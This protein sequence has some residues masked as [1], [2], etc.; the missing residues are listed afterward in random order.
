MEPMAKGR[1]ANT[2]WFISGACARPAAIATPS[3]RWRNTNHTISPAAPASRAVVCQVRPACNCTNPLS[4]ASVPPQ[5]SIRLSQ[6]SGDLSS[7]AAP[8]PGALPGTKR[9]D[10]HNEARQNGTTMEKIERHPNR[11][12][13]TPPTLGP[14]AGA[15]TAPRPKTLMAR[16]CSCGSKARMTMMAGI[17]CTTPQQGGV[18]SKVGSGLA[19]RYCKTRPDPTA[20]CHCWCDPADVP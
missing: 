17:G 20:V 4:S 3:R 5:A 1:L 6:S 8:P 10:I 11:S 15:S 12:T 9:A 16:P 13:S 19:L 14:S 7:W 2:A 18:T